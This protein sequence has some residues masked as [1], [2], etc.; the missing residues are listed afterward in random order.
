[1]KMG[2]NV[3]R[4][5]ERLAQGN[6]RPRIGEVLLDPSNYFSL[7]HLNTFL[8]HL[9]WRAALDRLYRSIQLR[10]RR[11]RA[12]PSATWRNHERGATTSSALC[13]YE[14]PS[15]LP[16]GRRRSCRIAHSRER[17]ATTTRGYGICRRVAS[18]L[19]QSVQASTTISK[20]SRRKWSCYQISATISTFCV[21]E[22]MPV[23]A[24]SKP[25]AVAGMHRNFRNSNE[26]AQAETLAR[27]QMSLSQ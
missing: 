10:D 18:T 26:R 16:G 20:S 5:R 12:L 6:D 19:Y 25:S 13:M 22:W 14:D 15:R 1:M 24:W 27:S 21:D 23:F 17:G 9:R 3:V 2:L 11:R 7:A 4:V 8:S